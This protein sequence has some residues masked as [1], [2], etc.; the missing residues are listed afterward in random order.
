[1]GKVYARIRAESPVMTSALDLKNPDTDNSV[2]GTINGAFTSMLPNKH[3][4]DFI[5]AKLKSRCWPN[6]KK[7]HKSEEYK[8]GT[9]EENECYEWGQ[10]FWWNSWCLSQQ[11]VTPKETLKGCFSCH[12]ERWISADLGLNLKKWAVEGV[13]GQQSIIWG[14]KT[15][16]WGRRISKTILSA[17]Q[18]AGQHPDS[19]NMGEMWRDGAAG[20]SRGT[21]LQPRRGHGLRTAC[22]YYNDTDQRR[23]GRKH[24]CLLQS[25]RIAFGSRGKMG[26]TWFICGSTSVGEHLHLRLEQ[27]RVL[28]EALGSKCS[29]ARRLSTHS[30]ARPWDNCKPTNPTGS[31]L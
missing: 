23:W 31:Q 29:F 7:S 11:I 2:E 21:R 10:E 5:A 24:S 16:G 13:L 3:N 28:P 17:Q 30:W 18:A 8:I 4:L 15:G 6:H 22:S 12:I 9:Q 1:M 14:S 20:W 26:L 25:M 27:V 19:T